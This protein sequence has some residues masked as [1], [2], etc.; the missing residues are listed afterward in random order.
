M[1]MGQV[2]FFLKK[3]IEVS[4]EEAKLLYDKA[5]KAGSQFAKKRLKEM[6]KIK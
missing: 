4:M 1:K 5:S 6:Q 3:A 2:W